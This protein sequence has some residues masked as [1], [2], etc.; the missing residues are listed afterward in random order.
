[1][2]ARLTHASPMNRRAHETEQE[3]ARRRL[4]ASL[5]M[6]G[7]VLV[8]CLMDAVL[9]TLSAHYPAMQV[10]ALRG[11]SSLP[12]VLV[13]AGL[14]TGLR[15]LL[16]VRWS[17]H[18]L[19]GAIGIMMMAAFVYALR[20][21]PLST[22][23]SIFFAAPL[24]ITALSVPIL[25]EH[26]GPR[27][28]TAIVIG[29]VGVLVVLRPTGGGVLTLAGLAVLASA[30]GRTD[31]SQAMVVWLMALMALGAG[32]MAWPQWVPLRMEHAWLVLALG[33]AGALGQY[34]ITEAFL[35]GEASLLAPL[36]YTALA[37]GVLLDLAIWRVLPDGVTWV[38]AA[39]IVGSGLYLIRR[40]GR[41]AKVATPP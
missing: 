6:L 28:W 29:F 18:L 37:W 19:R 31:S 41:A 8:F 2:R 22:A 10:A 34:L 23:Y 4:R 9:K 36:E 26:V 21:I 7:C 32:L 13:W 16:R 1:M 40:E 11:M 20:T 12:W 27:R 17:L 30:L 24:L 39:I 38:G 25:K 35:L 3:A 5:L 15:P 33:F 14:T